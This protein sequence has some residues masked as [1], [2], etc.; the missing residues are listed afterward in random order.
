MTVDR[1][2]AARVGLTEAAVGQLGRRRRSGAAPLGQVTLDGRQQNVV[3]RLRHAAADDGGA[4]AG[5]AGRPG[6]SWTTSPTSPRCEGPQQVTRIDGERSVTVTGTATGSNLGATTTELTEAAGRLDAAGRRSYTIGGVS[7]DQA[8]A[9]GDLGLAVL[10]AI[11]IVF[12]I[13]VATFRSLIQPLILLVSIPFAATGAIGLLLVTGTAAGRAGADRRADAGRHRG[14][15][16]DRA[17]RP[18]Q[19]VP[20]AGHGRP[21]GGDRG[22]P[23]PAAADPD[24]RGRDHLRAAADGARADRRGRLHLPA[25]GGRGDRRSAQL[26]AADAGAGADALHDGGAHQGVAAGSARTA[27][28]RRVGGDHDGDR[29]GASAEPGRGAERRRPP[30]SRPRACSR[31]GDPRR[32]PRWWRARTSSRCCGCRK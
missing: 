30:R 14:D 18:D 20:G 19:P 29:R 5:A 17:D 1:V 11:A 12:L 15:Q 6:R 9:F 26:D 21:G 16:R 32:R 28:L 25:A 10:A 27:A 7:A 31:P 4:A 2:A 13:M 23:A 24:D 3:L 8:D 22:R